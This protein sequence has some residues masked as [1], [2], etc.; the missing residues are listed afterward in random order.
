MIL[1]GSRG[2][3]AVAQR[4]IALRSKEIGVQEVTQWAKA[5]PVG[6]SVIDLGCGSGIPLTK[7]LEDQG[8]IVYG[9]DASMKMV[10]QFSKNLPE[11]KVACEDV[12]RSA[13]FNRKFD[14]VLAWGLLFL[15][16]KNEQKQLIKAIAAIM[17][18]GGQ[19]LFT[20]Q[21]EKIR[22]KDQ[23]TLQESVSLGEEEYLKNLKELGF[24]NVNQFYDVGKNH[25]FNMVSTK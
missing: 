12:C 14:G 24:E 25:Y 20:A 4:F 1:D 2:Y 16:K 17:R 9:I 6:G 8:L 13:F 10:E 5:L 7:I 19:F 18:P 3:D 22:W 11:A 15:L 23:L 21:K